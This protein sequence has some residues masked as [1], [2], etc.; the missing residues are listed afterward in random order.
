MKFTPEEEEK[1]RKDFEEMIFSVTGTA[2]PEMDYETIPSESSSSEDE[3]DGA[4][5]P[6]LLGLMRSMKDTE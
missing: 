4:K 3:D 5:E 1:A 2:L 6:Y